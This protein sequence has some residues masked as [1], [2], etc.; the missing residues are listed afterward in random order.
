L[1]N[2]RQSAVFGIVDFGK[3]D[4]SDYPIIEAA[5]SLQIRG[6]I[7][8]KYD[9]EFQCKNRLPPKLDPIKVGINIAPCS[10][11]KSLN[12][13]RNCQRCKPNEYS[14]T[15][16][17]CLPCPTGAVC[18]EPCP[19][20]ER[21]ESDL[22][23]VS[24]PFTAPGFWQNLASKT[25]VDGPDLN[26]EWWASD[27]VKAEKIRTDVDGENIETGQVTARRLEISESPTAKR[28]RGRKLGYAENLNQRRVVDNKTPYCDWSQDIC[29][30][31]EF[32]D[33]TQGA[34]ME[35][36]DKDADRLY[37]C[38][39]GRKFFTCP[40]G[41]AACPG[42]SQLCQDSITQEYYACKNESLVYQDDTTNNNSSA[43]SSNSGNDINNV[44]G[45]KIVVI[46]NDND[47]CTFGY[48]GVMCNKCIPGYWKTAANTCERCA[49]LDG[50]ANTSD[51][52]YSGDQ[53][54][55][56]ALYAIAGSFAL[57]F[58]LILLGLYLR[59]DEGACLVKL[60][61]KCCMKKKKKKKK[62]KIA[63]GN[64]SVKRHSADYMHEQQASMWFRPEKFKI[65]LAF[66]QIFSQMKS[67][68]GVR[69]P[70]LLAEYM[71][72]FSIVNVDIVKV[73]ALDCL[74]RS[75]Y[76]FGLSMVTLFPVM[77]LIFLFIVG[78]LGR[79]SYVTRLK[80]RPRKC[81]RSGK[82][83]NHWM[84]K[85]QYTKLR[86]KGAKAALQHDPVYQG[87]TADA[88]HKALQKEMGKNMS[89][90]PIGCSIHK[91]MDVKQ[92]EI[93]DAELNKIAKENI[94]I[95]K[96]NCSDRLE[97]LRF[98]NKLGKIFFWSLLLVY[99]SISTRVIRLFACTQIGE[100]TV[101]V[102]DNSIECFTPKW[103]SFMSGAIIAGIIF[104]IGIPVL[105]LVLLK[106]ERERDVE[107][108]WA[109]AKRFPKKRQM[110]LHE[111]KEDADMLGEFWTLDKDGDG[112][113]TIEEEEVAIKHY[114]RRKNMRFYRT[115][116]RLGFI[117]YAYKEDEWFYELTELMRK[118]ILNGF[119]VLVPQ[120][121]VSRVTVGMLVCL[122]FILILNHTRPYKAFSDEFLQNMCHI[123]LFMTMFCGLLLKG[124]V[125]FLGFSPHLREYERF[126]CCWTVIGSHAFCML[127][128]FLTIMYERFFSH[129]RRLLDAK[130]RRRE[131]ELKARLAKFK[132]AKKKLMS[133]VRS[134]RMFSVGLGM[135]QLG[136]GGNAAFLSALTQNTGGKAPTVLPSGTKPKP[137][138]NTSSI[139]QH[140]DF[141]W[142][143]EN[144]A[145]NLKT[146]E[147][148]LVEKTVNDGSETDSGH[149]SH[150]DSGSE[151]DSQHSH[152]D[153]GSETGSSH[154]DSGS[155]TDTDNEGKK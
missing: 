105:F 20:D 138:I 14:T 122:M 33:E 85:K 41:P 7:G 81:V 149:D 108:N 147:K 56:M 72:I 119:M 12:K 47:V 62:K 2:V 83:V 144:N 74:Y 65:M 80:F 88:K 115:Y 42:A 133:Q 54:S 17:A 63:P 26:S 3:M 75:D 34:C 28:E 82:V 43:A 148:R 31:G 96:I 10:P 73:A 92:R 44:N 125:P 132:R 104:V 141:S 116:D 95:W 38:I 137:V 100:V 52:D 118:L 102:F 55:S 76:Y 64:D 70:P 127:Y 98:Q 155:E 97:Y 15:G 112:E 37:Q 18:S 136:G 39:E 25:M 99:P 49:S 111:A 123:Q 69:W 6:E 152:T 129:E 21:C 66:V 87:M 29:L 27:Q 128:A 13:Q 150:T 60:C 35:L 32:F 134:N 131:A 1:T 24:H 84:S 117:Y 93:S 109:V 114:L 67:N 139:V 48:M 53:A 145:N 90:L 121:V 36:T 77:F 120:G 91:T 19:D 113:H 16:R 46:E 94:R 51:K 40:L 9:L 103:L 45:T 58:M 86:L 110:M 61:C 30:P 146:D 68:Y 124:E 5:E 106:T 78:L 71:R 143:G 154:T 135:G 126:I 57:T 11:G 130:D 79:A 151:T 142:P 89:S 59:Q 4:F 22:V 23:G 101:L 8:Y 50:D 140:G 107:K 153:S